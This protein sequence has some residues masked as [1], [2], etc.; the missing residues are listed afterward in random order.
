MKLTRPLK[1]IL[2]EAYRRSKLFNN[3][4]RSKS[5]LQQWLG[6]G[7]KSAYKSALNAGLMRW[8]NDKLPPKYCTGWLC[9]TEKGLGAMQSCEE[10]FEKTLTKATIYKGSYQERFALMGTLR[11]E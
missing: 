9:L 10:E 11:S 3:S 2:F 1:R 4:K 5:I 8:W 6:L 7:S